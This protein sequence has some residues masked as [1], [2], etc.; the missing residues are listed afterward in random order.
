MLCLSFYEWR[1]I[2]PGEQMILAPFMEKSSPDTAPGRFADNLF[3]PKHAKADVLLTTVMGPLRCTLQTQRI[4]AR[5]ARPSN[6]TANVGCGHLASHEGRRRRRSP[7]R[8]RPSTPPATSPHSPRR[9]G[10]PKGNGKR[11]RVAGRATRGRPT[12]RRSLGRDSAWHRGSSARPPAQ[13]KRPTRR[14]HANGRHEL[15]TTATRGQKSLP[16]HYLVF[17]TRTPPRHAVAAA[18]SCASGDNRTRQAPASCHI[19]GHATVQRSQVPPARILCRLHGRRCPRW[20]P[21]P[22]QWPRNPA[23]DKAAIQQRRHRHVPSPPQPQS[24]A[25]AAAAGSCR[26]RRRHRGHRLSQ[27]HR[28]SPVRNLGGG[29]VPV[30]KAAATK[31]TPPPHVAVTNPST[32][33]WRQRWRVCGERA[34][35]AG[36]SQNSG[37]QK[38]RQ[39][40]ESRAY[41]V[42]DALKDTRL[43]HTHPSRRRPAGRMLKMATNTGDRRGRQGGRLPPAPRAPAHNTRPTSQSP[44]AR[45]PPRRGGTCHRPPSWWHHGTPSHP[46]PH[47]TP[48]KRT[49]AV[50]GSSSK[51]KVPTAWQLQVVTATMVRPVVVRSRKAG[52][53]AAARAAASGRVAAASPRGRASRGSRNTTRVS[54]AGTQV[55]GTRLPP[56]GPMPPPHHQ[57]C[58]ASRPRFDSTVHGEKSQWTCGLPSTTAA[59]NTNYG[60]AGAARS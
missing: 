17:R 14:S 28:A 29:R 32:N 35:D 46:P 58:A 34:P 7:H 51:R 40:V 6:C 43:P 2:Y 27:S 47:P 22:P 15:L 42:V 21:P 52:T 57:R 12:A 3:V 49:D 36:D 31:G 8:L 50:A 54:T 1:C 33:D 9:S 19:R 48:R 10:R 44:G 39:C 20:P 13:G 11:R 5:L 24:E 41:G 59:P 37:R 56:P 4:P 60:R 18:E 53:M 16:P 25:T 45:P 55:R 23:P 38:R 26:C 30:T